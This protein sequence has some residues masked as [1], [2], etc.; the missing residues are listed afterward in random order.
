ME[1]NC[2]GFRYEFASGDIP[3]SMNVRD[4]TAAHSRHR[5]ASSGV[6][7]IATDWPVVPVLTIVLSKLD[8]R[9]LPKT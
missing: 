7:F 3:R 6:E 8:L 5:G 1:F 2:S 9:A 4:M